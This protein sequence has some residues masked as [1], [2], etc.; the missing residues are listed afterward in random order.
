MSITHTHVTS[1][2]CLKKAFACWQYSALGIK[3][4]SCIVLLTISRYA[5]SILHACY[6]MPYCTTLAP[7]SFPYFLRS[8]VK[9]SAV[10]SRLIGQSMHPALCLLHSTSSLTIQHFARH[11]HTAGHTEDSTV[12]RY[13][14]P[15]S[16]TVGASYSATS[17]HQSSLLAR[18][19]TTRTLMARRSQ[20]RTQTPK[21]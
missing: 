10:I 13:C 21:G 2:Q 5:L 20:P 19:C 8:N 16:S 15:R 18:R 11:R 3:P 4:R 9:E 6:I 7:V 14:S 12:V 1:S 17:W